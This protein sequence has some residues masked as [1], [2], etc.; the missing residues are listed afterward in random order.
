MSR[1]LGS[2]FHTASVKSRRFA[3][4]LRMS[5]FEG[6]AEVIGGKA[7]IGPTPPAQRVALQSISSF[8]PL[9][10]DRNAVFCYGLHEHENAVLDAVTIP[11]VVGG[12]EA[13]RHE[14][15]KRWLINLDADQR[16]VI[17]LA[18]AVTAGTLGGECGDG[19]GVHAGIHFKLNV[20]TAIIRYA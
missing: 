10:A 7:D 8:D 17:P 2:S 11:A 5:A 1:A 3:T 13:Q 15:L 4:T 12:N 6:E 18:L 9:V 14:A 19:L 16:S 20:R